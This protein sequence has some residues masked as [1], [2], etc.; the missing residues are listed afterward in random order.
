MRSDHACAVCYQTFG[1]IRYLRR[2]I[3]T[4]GDVMT[5]EQ[6]TVLRESA[7]PQ[8]ADA[9]AE[10]QQQR[11]ECA[12]CHKAYTYRRPYEAHLAKCAK[13]PPAAKPSAA[14]PETSREEIAA[15]IR[16]IA[17][18]LNYDKNPC[19]LLEP[20]PNPV[21]DAN[22]TFSNY[23]SGDV[24]NRLNA[25]LALP[26]TTLPQIKSKAKQMDFCIYQ[27]MLE[28][29]V[30]GRVVRHRNF[31]KMFQNDGLQLGECLICRRIFADSE[32]FMVHMRECAKLKHVTCEYCNVLF[33]NAMSK[34]RHMD[35]CAVKKH[36]VGV[37][38]EN[39]M[40]VLPKLREA[41]SL[42]VWLLS[43]TLSDPDISLFGRHAERL[44]EL[45]K[46]WQRR[47]DAGAPASDDEDSDDSD[48]P[49]AAPADT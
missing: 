4:H 33:T 31:R 2:H 40:E 3:E 42:A 22:V 17:H 1:D 21:A 28:S 39:A 16:E 18:I 43:E 14:G 15:Q 10:A 29:R 46:A 25:V 13:A 20:S 36:C 7:W 8:T 9:A 6:M 12:G 19:S 32:E 44:P 27:M 47:H 24:A 26:P 30:L 35:K 48:E 49:A 23:Q 38:P 41:E 11:F 5:P 45:F 34:T 37:H